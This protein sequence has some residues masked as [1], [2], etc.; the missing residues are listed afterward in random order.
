M[1]KQMFALALV[2]TGLGLGTFLMQGALAQGAAAEEEDKL[3]VLPEFKA[4]D[5]NEDGM[6]DSTEVE[7]LTE[8]LKERHAIDFQFRAVDENGDGLINDQEY[9]AYDRMLAERLG[10]A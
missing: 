9:V 7:S 6:I 4:V 1:K 10:I 3:A 8:T 5:A 2:A